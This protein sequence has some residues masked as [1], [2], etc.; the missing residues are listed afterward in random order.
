MEMVKLF[1]VGAESYG[2]PKLREVYKKGQSFEVEA[3]VAAKMQEA[4]RVDVANN[5]HPVLVPSGHPLAAKYEADDENQ[6]TPTKKVPAK[7]AATRK[8]KASA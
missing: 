7:R 8:K 1:V 2:S 4:V 5:V 3:S 6:V